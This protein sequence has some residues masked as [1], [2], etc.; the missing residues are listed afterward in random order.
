DQR[1]PN[2][3]RRL[4]MATAPAQQDPR[5]HR[6]VVVGSDLRTALGAARAWLDDRLT[7]G[8][9][10]GEH[11]HEAADRRAACPEERE[12]HSVPPHQAPPLQP[13]VS[14]GVQVRAMVPFMDRVTLKV[15]GSVEVE[16]VWISYWSEV[17]WLTCRCGASS[18][19]GWT[20]CSS[21]TVAP[22]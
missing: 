7:A 15:T 11:V 20:S 3:D 21:A 5:D 2:R 17:A 19:D 9:P 22:L 16:D 14:A 12:V 8:Q 6:D 18:R 13:P 10:V 1:I 4:A